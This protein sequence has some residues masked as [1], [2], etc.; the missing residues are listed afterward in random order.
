MSVPK[1]VGYSQTYPM[2]VTGQFQ[3]IWVEFELD[4]TDDPRQELYKCKKI[5]ND[6]FFESNKASEKQ[7]QTVKEEPQSQEAKIIAQ[8]YASSD[9]K[10]LESFKL[11]ARNTKSIQSAYEQRLKEL[12]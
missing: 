8:I 12:S 3:K 6:F 1:S 9:L 10:V 7:L 2:G 4:D 5:V 11:L